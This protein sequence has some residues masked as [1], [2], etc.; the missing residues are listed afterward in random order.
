MRVLTS[1]IG[2]SAEPAD[3]RVRTH[4]LAVVVILCKSLRHCSQKYSSGLVASS[5]IPTQPP[6]C[7]TLHVSHCI[8]HPVVSSAKDAGSDPFFETAKAESGSGN[9]GYS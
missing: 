4:P 6:C 9:P 2:L 1:R 3:N 8:N 5:I 7:Q